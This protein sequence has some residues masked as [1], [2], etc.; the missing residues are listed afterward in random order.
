MIFKMHWALND[1]MG[2]TGVPVSQT[3]LFARFHEINTG[4]WIPSIQWIRAFH[5]VSYPRNPSF[6]KCRNLEDLQILWTVSRHDGR[7]KSVLLDQKII[8]RDQL[9]GDFLANEYAMIQQFL[10]IRVVDCRPRTVLENYDR[11][12]IGEDN[13]ACFGPGAKP[14][15]QGDLKM[16]N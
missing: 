4:Q 5:S 11:T 1:R 15:G 7:D 9:D 2:G 14:T 10:S 3:W 8:I 12:N 16:I 6:N 13:F